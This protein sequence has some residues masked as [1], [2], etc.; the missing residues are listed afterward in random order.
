VSRTVR[1]GCLVWLLAATFTLAGPAAAL[2]VGVFP[3][4]AGL[5]QGFG[6]SGSPSC[7][8]VYTLDS[9]ASVGGGSTITFA[10]DLALATETVTI[11]LVDVTSVFEAGGETVTFSSLSYTGSIGATVLPLGG[12]LFL[13]QQLGAATGAVTGT[14]TASLGGGGDIDLAPDLHSLQCVVDASGTGVCG[15]T[16]GP[17]SFPVDDGDEEL[18]FQHTFNLNIPEPGTWM[19]MVVGLVG[20]GFMGSRRRQP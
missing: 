11:S 6:Y 2:T 19:L 8:T 7:S 14:Y 18:T 17:T 20:L 16:F 5:D 4:S 9:P 12:G 10:D 13:V 15:F 3:S 1:I